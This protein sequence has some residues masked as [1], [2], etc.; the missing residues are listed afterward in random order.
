MIKRRTIWLNATS[1]V[2]FRVTTSHFSGVVTIIYVYNQST[3][4][5]SEYHY[6][7]IQSAP[8]ICMASGSM[9]RY[10]IRRCMHYDGVRVMAYFGLAYILNLI[11][12]HLLCPRIWRPVLLLIESY[13]RLRSSLV[14]KAIVSHRSNLM[15]PLE[16]I[17]IGGDA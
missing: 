1:P 5:K 6:N 11:V 9:L 12:C 14:V 8:L 7:H 4:I 15:T 3:L 13:I 2:L 10:A 16:R 17:P